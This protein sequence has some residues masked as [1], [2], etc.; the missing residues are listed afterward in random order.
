MAF[1]TSE[2]RGA[3][4]GSALVVA[5]QSCRNSAFYRC[6]VADFLRILFMIHQ[7]NDIFDL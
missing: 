2:S 5:P 1:A 3:L 4:Q 6:F 7:K